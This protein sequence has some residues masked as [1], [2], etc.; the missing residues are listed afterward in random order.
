MSWLDG[1]LLAVVVTSTLH[2][3]WTLRAIDRCRTSIQQSHQSIVSSCLSIIT[4]QGKV[5]TRNAMVLTE[6]RRQLHGGDVEPIEAKEP[7]YGPEG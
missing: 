6:L 4:E 7:G 5:L 2:Q 1:V 3:V